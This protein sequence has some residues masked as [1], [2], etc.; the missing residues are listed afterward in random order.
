M[1]RPR[2]RNAAYYPHDADMR[3]DLKVKAI[4]RK[5]GHLGYSIWVMLLEALTNANEFTLEW[6]E[7][8]IELI[9]GDFDIESAEL[10][11]L[12][13]YFEKLGLLE[14]Q[15]NTIFSKKLINRFDGLLKK[16]KRTRKVV[17]DDHN[18]NN[19]QLQSSI[20]PKVKESKVN[21][22]K[23]KKNKVNTIS[24]EIVDE[25]GNSSTSKK[26]NSFLIPNKNQVAAK[27]IEY[28]GGL[29]EDWEYKE[30]ANKI[31][32][33][34]NGTNWHFASGGEKIRTESDFQNII[35]SWGEKYV[36]KKRNISSEYHEDIATNKRIDITPKQKRSVL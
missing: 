26:N 12:I 13:S 8:S 30:Q 27:L 28:S 19:N 6:N 2:S 7:L 23:V 29:L 22:I 14:I 3:N 10:I 24:N 4:R 32:N 17:T 1:A 25:R 5:F 15:D 18:S 20:A 21:E 16:R 33:F 36:A 9:A 31:V 34:Y 35:S 11:T